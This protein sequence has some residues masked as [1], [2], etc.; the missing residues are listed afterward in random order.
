M[1]RRLDYKTGKMSVAGGG[2]LPSGGRTYLVPSR[3]NQ[4]Y[5]P[6]PCCLSMAFPFPGFPQHCAFA[7]TPSASYFLLLRLT[8]RQVDMTAVCVQLAP[9]IGLTLSV[10][11]FPC[12]LLE[13][14]D[15]TGLASRGLGLQPYS[16]AH[17]SWSTREVSVP[18]EPYLCFLH[19][20]AWPDTRL[21]IL[22]SLLELNHLALAVQMDRKQ[23]RVLGIK[24]C[25]WPWL[26]QGHG[27]QPSK[28]F[29]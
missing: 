16:S 20:R 10:W 8:R 22:P 7:H 23:A 26:W 27:Y 13:D 24:F 29:S 21:A 15:I 28:R 4:I 18:L 25:S 17:R 14:R 6:V 1:Q 2:F 11:V 3:K 12:G 5:P 9:C 19:W